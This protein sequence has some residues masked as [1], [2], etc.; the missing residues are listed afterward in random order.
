MA[1]QATE[2]VHPRETHGR[3]RTAFKPRLPSSKNWD[4]VSVTFS[5]T[6]RQLAR[7]TAATEKVGKNRSRIVREAIAAYL[8]TIEAMNS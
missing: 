4:V 3:K 7:L 6:P 2:Q 1:Q 5:L 8:A